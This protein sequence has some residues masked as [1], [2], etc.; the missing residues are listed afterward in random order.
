MTDTLWLKRLKQWFEAQGFGRAAALCLPVYRPDLMERAAAALGLAH[1]DYRARH[2]L[3][4]G[5]QA[6]RLTLADMETAVHEALAASSGKGLLVQNAEALLSLRPAGERRA[7]LERLFEL[8]FDGR[9][10]VSFCLYAHELPHDDAGRCLSF[11]A[12]E[13]PE[14]RLLGRLAGL[15]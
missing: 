6:S 7:W 13:L 2:M 3:P 12:L 5:W 4:L 11:S 15:R 8:S 9:V 10:V 1:F 14:E